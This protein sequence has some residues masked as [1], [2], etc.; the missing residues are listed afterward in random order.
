VTD[1]QMTSS[2]PGSG[3]VKKVAVNVAEDWIGGLQ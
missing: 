3:R 1:D 2:S